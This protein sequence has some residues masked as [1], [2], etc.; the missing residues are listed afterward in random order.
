M[1]LLPLAVRDGVARRFL[2]QG[3]RFFKRQSAAEAAEIA[4]AGFAVI[5]RFSLKVARAMFL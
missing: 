4:Y 1:K 3:K 2:G 5:K